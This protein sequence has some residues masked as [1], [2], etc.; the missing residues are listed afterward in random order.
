MEPAL[1]SYVSCTA[2]KIAN[3]PI[4]YIAKRLSGMDQYQKLT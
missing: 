3:P 2:K 1:V 4:S